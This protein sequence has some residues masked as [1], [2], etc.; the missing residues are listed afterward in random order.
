MRVRYR[1][2]ANPIT[3]Q[4]HPANPAKTRRIALNGPDATAWWSRHA[5]R[6]GLTVHSA[7]A[8]VRAFRR[9][10]PTGPCH[11]LIQFDGLATI[12]DAD[13]LRHALTRGIGK[14]KAYGAGLLTLAPA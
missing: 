10:D 9:R 5:T 4:P 1:I 3:L 8:A 12:A 14:A 11:S 13:R 7:D 6:A 2:T